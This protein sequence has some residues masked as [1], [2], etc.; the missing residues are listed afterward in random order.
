MKLNDIVQREIVLDRTL[1]ALADPTRRAIVHRLIQGEATVTELAA[2]FDI[3]LAAVSKHI[4]VLE[5]AELVTRRRVWREHFVSFNPQPLDQLAG[6]I[7]NQRTFWKQRLQ[8]L[9]AMLAKEDRAASTRKRTNANK[10]SS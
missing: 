1:Q 5:D 2:P 8:A 6:W 9:D 10:G 7:D 4:R 3:S